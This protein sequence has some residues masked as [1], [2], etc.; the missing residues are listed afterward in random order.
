MYATSM[1]CMIGLHQA[2]M[3]SRRSPP[4]EKSYQNPVTYPIP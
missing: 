2:H 1:V 3:P 4:L